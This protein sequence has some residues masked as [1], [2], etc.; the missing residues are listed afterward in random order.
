MFMFVCGT[1]RKISSTL[2][3]F[4]LAEEGVHSIFRV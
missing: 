4:A 1:A 3:F 2:T